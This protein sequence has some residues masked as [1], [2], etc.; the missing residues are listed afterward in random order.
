MIT[1]ELN[2][3]RLQDALRRVEWAVGDVAPLMRG[4][5]AELA[6]AKLLCETVDGLTEADVAASMRAGIAAIV[7]RG[8]AAG[9]ESSSASLRA[10]R[11]TAGDLRARALRVC[12]GSES[13]ARRGAGSAR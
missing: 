7:A 2:H 9:R 10:C 5:A 1:V 13:P 12:A 4:I 11:S 6:S 8:G 3:Q